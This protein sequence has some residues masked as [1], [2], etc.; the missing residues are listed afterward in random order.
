MDRLNFAALLQ[1]S[2]KMHGH[3]CPGQVLG[4]RMS[5]LGLREIGI[6]DPKGTQR[7]NLIVFVEMDRCATDAV[8]SVTGCSLG[9]R[10]MKFLDYGKMAA[11]YLN[12]KTGRAIRIVA[13]EQ[14]RV[15]A[16]EYFPA[17]ENKYTG[18]LEAYKV[19]SATELFE[20]M[21][22]SVKVRPED[23]PGRPLQRVQCES[24]GE[25]VQDGREICQDGKVLCAPCA[26]GSYYLVKEFF[27]EVRYAE[28]S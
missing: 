10:T 13:R 11:T 27:S 24:C 14:S 18:Q 9:H 4:V 23:M 19:M 15:Q 25:H 2:V 20:V 28:K 1:E 17:I 6:R 21:E 3:L 16:K 12:L 7:K 8:Q 26:Q 5:M 22:V